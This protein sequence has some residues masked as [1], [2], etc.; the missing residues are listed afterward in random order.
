[1]HCTDN[2]FVYVNNYL[3]TWFCTLLCQFFERINEIIGAK[4]SRNSKWW[5]IGNVDPSYFV[6]ALVR[7]KKGFKNLKPKYS[8][9]KS[10]IKH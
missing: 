3:V 2:I 5:L 6:R 8:S 1:M 4:L 9:D 7:L 10:I